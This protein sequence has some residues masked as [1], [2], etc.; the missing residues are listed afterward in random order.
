MKR[1]TAEKSSLSPLW[2][3]LGLAVLAG[4]GL[5]LVVMSLGAGPAAPTPTQLPTAIPASPTPEPSP[6]PSSTATSEPAEPTSTPM[7]KP[8][9]TTPAPRPAVPDVAP[10]FTLDRVGGGTFTLKDQLEEGPVV[11]VFFERCG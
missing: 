6:T 1:S 7:A 9:T 11:L 5:V 10:D 2:I 4:A 3:I 8:P